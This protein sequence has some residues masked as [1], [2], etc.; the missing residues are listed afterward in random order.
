MKIFGLRV[1]KELEVRGKQQ[2]DLCEY[3]QVK[4][5]T[6]SEWLNGRNEPP[7]QKIVEIAKFLEVSTDYL[8]G[9][10]E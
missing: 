10:D 8:L 9:M 3:L 1:K 6:L 7:M 5:S 2:K 4:K